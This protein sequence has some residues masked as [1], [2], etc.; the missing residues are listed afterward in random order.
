MNVTPGCSAGAPSTAWA[1]GCSEAETSLKH[2]GGVAV[3]AWWLDVELANSWSAKDLGLNRATIQGATD[4]L[5]STGF[6]VG[7]YSTPIS[8]ATITGGVFT[9]NGSTA[10]WVAGGTC[11]TA[12]DGAPVWLSQFTSGGFD[13]DTAC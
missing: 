12:F 8:W 9:P 4:R 6:P 10:E 3:S 1:I 2:V 13:Y 5:A 11:G 7:V